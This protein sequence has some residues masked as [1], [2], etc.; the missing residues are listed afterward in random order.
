MFLKKFVHNFVN[1]SLTPVSWIYVWEISSPWGIRVVL[2]VVQ[3]RDS[4]CSFWGE[5]RRENICWDWGQANIG[6][7]NTPQ[8]PDTTSRQQKKNDG[9]T[10][11]DGEECKIGWEGVNMKWKLRQRSSEK[12]YNLYISNW[13]CLKCQCWLCIDGKLH[14]VKQIE[15]PLKIYS[16]PDWIFF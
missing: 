9:K 7:I 12:T 15:N 5:W 13:K 6:R 1:I 14:E 3:T 10:A 4:F 11:G 8:F 16:H 2:D